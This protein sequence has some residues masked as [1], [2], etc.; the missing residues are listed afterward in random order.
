MASC[1]LYNKKTDGYSLIFWSVLRQW[2]LNTFMRIDLEHR[3]RGSAQL[4]Q[5]LNTG[6]TLVF[7]VCFHKKFLFTK[8]DGNLHLNV[9]K[10]L[11]YIP[12]TLKNVAQTP[13]LDMLHCLR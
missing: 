2:A 10:P 12:Q 5:S 1:S 4:G 6:S 7:V 8:C 13:N 9:T 11:L 3:N